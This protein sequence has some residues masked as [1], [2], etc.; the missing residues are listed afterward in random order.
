[1]TE[2]GLISI[3]VVLTLCGIKLLALIERDEV[4]RRRLLAESVLRRHGMTAEPY[5]ASAGITDRELAEALDVFAAS[6]CVVVDHCGTIV[7]DLCQRVSAGRHLLIVSRQ[8]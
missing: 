1:M 7:G 3:G 4:R 6:G 2:L 8:K 5:V